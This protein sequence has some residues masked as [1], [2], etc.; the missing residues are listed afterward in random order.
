VPLTLFVGYLVL[1]STKVLLRD[2]FD[3]SSWI[4]NLPIANLTLT[5]AA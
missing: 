1:V 3:G 2:T 4:M 5:L